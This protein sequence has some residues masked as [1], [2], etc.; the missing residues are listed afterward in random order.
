MIEIEKGIPVP[1]RGRKEKYPWSRLEVED[2]FFV[3]GA[4]TK[5]FAAADGARKKYG[6]KITI[7]TVDG[8]IRVWRVG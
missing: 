2:S 1:A 7:R 6:F 8:G 3:A 5:R 4:K